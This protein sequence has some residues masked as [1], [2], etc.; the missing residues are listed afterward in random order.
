MKLTI[1][2]INL[3]KAI[4]KM[5]REA[6]SH[7]QQHNGGEVQ[8]YG[9][10]ENGKV[11]EFVYHEIIGNGSYLESPDLIY[12]ARDRFFDPLHDEDYQE[13]W[14]NEGREGM[15]EEF[16]EENLGEW[17]DLVAEWQQLQIDDNIREWTQNKMN[18]IIDELEQKHDLNLDEITE[19]VG[20]VWLAER[21]GMTQQNVSL[22]GQ[23]ALK[24]T[25]RGEFL[26]PDA[27]VEGRPLWEKGNAEKYIETKKAAH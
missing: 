5:I 16:R 25:Y 27:V 14:T 15:W 11:T 2:R 23:R 3:A 12:L 22:A 17:L 1:N 9:V 21:L 13:W 8:L 19:Y 6:A 26:K 24:P 18:L 7:D 4:E 20:A 10:V